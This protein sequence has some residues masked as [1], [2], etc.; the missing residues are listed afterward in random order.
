MAPAG[1]IHLSKQE[2]LPR[3]QF[4]SPR[5]FQPS[6]RGGAELHPP[7]GG[8]QG[9]GGRM[10]GRETVTRACERTSR[11]RKLRGASRSRGAELAFRSLLREERDLQRNC[12]W[13]GGGK[14]GQASKSPRGQ[15]RLGPGRGP[16]LWDPLCCGRL[17]V[18]PVRGEFLSCCGQRGGGRVQR[19]FPAGANARLPAAQNNLC[20]RGTFRGDIFR[21]LSRPCPCLVLH[22]STGGLSA[23]L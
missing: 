17:R 20:Q 4:S 9:Q 18:I 16:R 6:V 7:G 22:R 10:N 12:G 11:R 23:G 13:P 14:A 8:S 15:K 3:F 19:A 2:G 21:F 1:E 5:S